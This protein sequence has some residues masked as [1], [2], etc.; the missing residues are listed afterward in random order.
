MGFWDTQSFELGSFIVLDFL[1][2]LPV[3][4]RPCYWCLDC[5]TL[6]FLLLD[7]ASDPSHIFLCATL[8]TPMI[9]YFVFQEQLD[10]FSLVADELSLLA[11]RLR[12]MVIAE[13]FI[14]SFC[15]CQIW[16]VAIIDMTFL[17]CFNCAYL[18]WCDKNWIQISF[19]GS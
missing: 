18:I 3:Y 14:L 19:T 13:V 16:L 10:P 8:L 11:N 5:Q 15:I 4:E 7:T 2:I 1:G 12:S 6:G 17:F 9:R